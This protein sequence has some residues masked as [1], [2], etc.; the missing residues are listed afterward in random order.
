MTRYNKATGEE[1]FSTEQAASLARISYVTLRRW[2]ASG[3]FQ[4]WLE[5]EGRRPLTSIELSN[6]KRIWQFGNQDRAALLE[7]RD[8]P[9]RRQR[10]ATGRPRAEVKREKN[11]LKNFKRLYGVTVSREERERKIAFRR[12]VKA[13]VE[14]RN[15]GVSP[16]DARLFRMPKKHIPESAVMEEVTKEYYAAAMTETLREIF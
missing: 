6:G 15:C 12:Y 5:E 9:E 7:Y 3:D 13:L 8:L 14:L 1:F 4:A 2:L 11:A 10:G 16:K